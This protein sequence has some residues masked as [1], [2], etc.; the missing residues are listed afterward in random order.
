MSS[1]RTG[2]SR[3]DKQTAQGLSYQ[4]GQSNLG[5]TSDGNKVIPGEALASSTGPSSPRGGAQARP[6]PV[7]QALFRP[8][9]TVRVSPVR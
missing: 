2:S 4:G 6:V 9:E 1:N 8:A 3:L 5:Y 7:A